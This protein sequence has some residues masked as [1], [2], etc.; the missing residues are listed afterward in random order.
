MSS[1]SGGYEAFAFAGGDVRDA[2]TLGER[3]PRQSANNF[4]GEGA[5]GT[6]EGLEKGSLG[7]FRE[8]C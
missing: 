6:S 8:M 4:G 1:G 7:L 5:C 2:A 3:A